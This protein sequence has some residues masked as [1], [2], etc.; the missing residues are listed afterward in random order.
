MD[1]VG[2]NHFEKDPEVSSNLRVSTLGAKCAAFTDRMIGPACTRPACI[3][4]CGRV[5]KTR[6][7]AFSDGVIAV[8]ITIMV[9]ELRPPHGSDLR[10]LTPVI[11]TFLVYL[12]S[13]INVG[14]YW[15]NHHHMFATVKRIDGRVMW[16][17]LHLLFWL[18]LTPFTVNWISERHF[19]ALP[20]A[21]YGG[22][23]LMAALAYT[24]LTRALTTIPENASLS[25]AVGGDAKGLTSLGS[26][27]LAIPLSFVNPWIAVSLYIAVAVVWFVPDPRIERRATR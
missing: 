9:L 13:F 2:S 1:K 22:V 17:N 25:S 6:L 12:L 15:N 5:E 26:Y 23:L 3:E 8:I 18:S 14:I 24:L 20:T 4:R 11:P 27:V 19:A 7:E 10:A 21:L 16:S